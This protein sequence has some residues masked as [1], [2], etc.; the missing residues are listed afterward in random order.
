MRQQ[1]PLFAATLPASAQ[2]IIREALTL[3]ESQLREPGRHLPPAMLSGT[4]YACN[5]PRQSGKNLLRS[6]S[7][8]SIAL[9]LTKRSSAALSTILRSIPAKW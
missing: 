3:L 9:L 1:L 5:S 2:Q 7:I 6:S 4:G 8:T